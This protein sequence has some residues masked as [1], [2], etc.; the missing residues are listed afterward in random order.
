VEFSTRNY[1]A[2]TVGEPARFAIT[3][4]KV[5]LRKYSLIRCRQI[6]F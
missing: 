6:K 2:D 4:T 1:L 3:A 5:K